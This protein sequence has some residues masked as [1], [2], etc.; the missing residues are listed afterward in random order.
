M[1]ALHACLL[2]E[3]GLLH[4][5]LPGTL[6]LLGLHAL[7]GLLWLSRLGLL[8]LLTLL[9]LIGILPLGR[10]TASLPLLRSRLAL[11]RTAPLRGPLRLALLE[12]IPLICLLSPLGILRLTL[13]S[14]LTFKSCLRLPCLRIVLPLLGH[15]W[16]PLGNVLTL[17]KV[18]PLRQVLS[19]IC[20]WLARLLGLILLDL[21]LLVTLQLP[22]GSILCLALSGC[23]ALLH[24]LAL[25]CLIALLSAL[26]LTCCLALL[27]TLPL[28]ALLGLSLFLLRRLRLGLP[29]LCTGRPGHKKLHQ[30]L[31][32]TQRTAFLKGHDG[33]LPLGL[34]GQ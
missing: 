21:P 33:R 3:E 23:L 27:C 16:L 12:I 5:G 32:K 24:H 34:Q 28:L 11:W 22:L 9:G 26:S 18:L 17:R 14:I 15:L 29:P 6:L 2:L 19:L 4:Q 20:L 1:L 25:P 10:S 13:R 8:G 30:L 7:L 31:Q